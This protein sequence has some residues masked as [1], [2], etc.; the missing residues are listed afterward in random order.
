MNVFGSH[1]N[2]PT[3]RSRLPIRPVLELVGLWPYRDRR[4]A[5]FSFSMKQRLALVIALVNDPEFLILDEPFVD[6]DPDGVLQLIAVLRQWA[7]DRKHRHA[8]LQLQE[9]CERFLFIK[10]GRLADEN[11]YFTEA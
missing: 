7:S 9:L 5:G 3:H 10:G 2:R 8:H 1:C 11:E 6:L 4:P